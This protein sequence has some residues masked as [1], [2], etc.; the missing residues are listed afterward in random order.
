MSRYGYLEV[1]QRVLGIRGNESRLFCISVIIGNWAEWSIWV[2]TTCSKTCCSG[3]QDR[4]RNRTCTDPAPVGTDEGCDGDAEE[5][6][7][8]IL[9]NTQDC[10]CT[11][12]C[13]YSCVVFVFLM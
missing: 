10:P 7:T 4:S 13:F 1:F 3:V 6:E 8:D 9:C 2:E 5:T 12:S 11:C